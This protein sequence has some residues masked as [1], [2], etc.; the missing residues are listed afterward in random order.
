MN[1]GASRQLVVNE[2]ASRQLVK[3]GCVALGGLAAKGAGEAGEGP[4]G[5]AV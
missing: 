5:E 1:E 2:D 3:A 4:E